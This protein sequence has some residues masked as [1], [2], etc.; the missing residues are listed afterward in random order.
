MNV[1]IRERAAGRKRPRDAF[2]VAGARPGQPGDDGPADRGGHGTDRFGISLGRDGES[3]FDQIHAQTV[4]LDRQTHL[5][6]NP[7]RVSGG[8][9]AVAQGG[10]EDG[11]PIASHER[12]SL[13]VSFW[14]GAGITTSL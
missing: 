8:L 12:A 2:D 1:W 7:H 6:V 3:G 11:Q 5:L 13:M 4:E 10:V 9:L 14:A